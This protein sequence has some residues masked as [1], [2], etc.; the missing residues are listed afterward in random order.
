[1]KAICMELLARG[2]PFQIF[3]CYQLHVMLCVLG[4][5]SCCSHH[6]T[7]SQFVTINHFYIISRTTTGGC[8]GTFFSLVSDS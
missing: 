5:F 7:Y 6:F 3:K 8:F 2:P 1:M 4:F